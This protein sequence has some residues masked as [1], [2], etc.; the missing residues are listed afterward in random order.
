MFKC[1][2]SKVVLSQT[3]TR[4]FTGLIL[5]PAQ[6]WSLHYK[7]ICK[8][9]ILPP[10]TRHGLFSK[11]KIVICGTG[12]HH[13]CVTLIKLLSLHTENQHISP[14]KTISE[15]LQTR[16]LVQAVSIILSLLFPRDCSGRLCRCHG[17][18]TQAETALVETPWALGKSWGAHLLMDLFQPETGQGIWFNRGNKATG[19]CIWTQRI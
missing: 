7:I 19:C 11:A 13:A 3:C 10:S 17:P 15:L 14:L 16:E 4:L 18:L 2:R 12:T 5:F 1:R 6:S 8:N 9:V